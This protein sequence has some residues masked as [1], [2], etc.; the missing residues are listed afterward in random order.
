M[1]LGWHLGPLSDIASVVMGAS[2]PGATYNDL[3]IGVPLVNGPVEYGDFFVEKKK[4]T[5]QP[6]RLSCKGDLILCVRGSTGRRAFA[7]DEYCLGRGVCA[8]RALRSAQALINR[9][10]LDGLAEL[11]SKTTG[12]VFPNLSSKD[13]KSLRVVVPPSPIVELYCELVA[14]LDRRIWTNVSASRILSTLGDTLL[15]KLISGELSVRD[16][17]RLVAEAAA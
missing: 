14:P 1:P 5:T 11:L 3:G 6:T 8:I 9:L 10:V 13:I 7:D 2:P 16:A 4:W 17:K 12:S 15:P